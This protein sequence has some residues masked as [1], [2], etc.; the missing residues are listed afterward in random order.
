LLGTAACQKQKETCRYDGKIPA[1]MPVSSSGHTHL[2]IEEP[3][4]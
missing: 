1:H 2:S 3:L 4:T